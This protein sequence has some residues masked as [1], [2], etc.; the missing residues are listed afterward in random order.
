M[1]SNV[2]E[3]TFCWKADFMD[4]S[5]CHNSGYASYVS[6]LYSKHPLQDYGIDAKDYRTTIY[7]FPMIVF[8]E[9][10]D[11]TVEFVGMYNFNLD[12]ATPQPF[13]FKHAD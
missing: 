2:G 8:Q 12:K 13:G 6:T 7:G 3:S 4:S 5:R 11:G 1:D 9:K 10:Q